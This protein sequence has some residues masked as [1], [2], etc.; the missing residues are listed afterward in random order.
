MQK[1]DFPVLEN[2]FLPIITKTI[3]SDC[4]ELKEI[5]GMNEGLENKLI[6]AAHSTNNLNDFINNIVSIKKETY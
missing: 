6:S 3:C 4:E 2:L 5:Y 1:T